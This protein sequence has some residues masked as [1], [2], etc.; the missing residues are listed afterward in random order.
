LNKLLERIAEG[1]MLV[2]DGAMG[3][4]LFKLGLQP[5]GCPESVNLTDRGLLEK[6]AREYLDAGAEIIQA[7]T[8]GASP[9]KLSAYGLEDRTEEIN[10]EAV[11]AVRRV[12][13][14]RAYVAC[15]C[16]P[17]GKILK[18][19]GDAEPED[20]SRGFEC[21]MQTL[22]DSGV[23]VICIETMIDL[24]EATMAVKAAKSI[25][26]HIPVCATMTFDKTP[27]GFFTIMGVSIEQAVKGLREA[28]ADVVGSN[29]GNGIE[30]MI[31]IARE[32]REST[33]LPVIIQSNAGQPESRNG[34][35]FY[36]ETPGFFA[37][38]ARELIDIGV[39]II[40]GCCGTTPEHIQ[41]IRRVVDSS[42]D[43]RE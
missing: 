25:S 3:T 8:F 17:S 19:Y 33:D 13:G 6:I 7:N 20:L 26:P 38:K 11:L 22:I 41:A 32:F 10:S 39:S 15:S 31:E 5:G 14:D 12:V 36:S 40:G 37:E 30:N 24:Q 2:A 4:M 16:G 29:C 34:T 1:E 42:N 27:R 28:G 9:I 23:D 18:P 43:S 21:Q 35:L